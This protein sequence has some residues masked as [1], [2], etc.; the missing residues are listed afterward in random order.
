MKELFLDVAETMDAWRVF[1]RL[2]LC[3]F[4]MILIDVHY[5]YLALEVRGPYDLGYVTAVWGAVAAVTKFYV[6]SGRNWTP[7]KEEPPFSFSS[8]PF[9]QFN[10]YS[11]PR[12]PEGPPGGPLC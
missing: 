5:W 12:G 10:R 8:S 4:Y 3:T 6:D 1:P 7:P 11:G 9:E 2:F